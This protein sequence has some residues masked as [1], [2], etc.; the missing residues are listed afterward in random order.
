MKDDLKTDFILDVD[1]LRRRARRHIENGAVTEDYKGNRET[2][3]RL[4]NEALATELVCV[5]R[6]KHDAAMAVGIHGDPVAAEFAEHAVEEQGHADLIAARI[7]QLGGDPDYNPDGLKTR[8]HSEYVTRKSLVEMIRENLVAERI[9][10]D[11]YSQMIRYIGDTDTTTRRMLEEILAK[12]EEHAE[13]LS[14]LLATLD[15]TE[16]TSPPVNGD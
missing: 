3:I 9:A 12:E 8:S 11:S 6:Y 16:K 13:D 15:P 7:T 14:D 5:L 2:V 4:L 10:I 1:E